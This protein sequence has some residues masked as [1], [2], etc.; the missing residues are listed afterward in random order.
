[1]SLPEI[2]NRCLEKGWARF[3]AGFELGDK[4]VEQVKQAEA[5]KARVVKQI[6]ADVESRGETKP[7]RSGRPP[8]KLSDTLKQA[9]QANA[10]AA[11]EMR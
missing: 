6:K 4:A 10:E 11:H 1:M 2:V 7:V 5:D 8:N 9:Q 3:E